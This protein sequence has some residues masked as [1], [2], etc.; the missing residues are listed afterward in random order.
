MLENIKNNDS[1]K[2]CQY[3]KIIL[4]TYFDDNFGMW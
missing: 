3:K 4:Y 2:F 1:G